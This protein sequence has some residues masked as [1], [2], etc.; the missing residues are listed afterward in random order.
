MRLRARDIA[1]AIGN[2]IQST[3]LV[4]S[5][6]SRAR[7]DGR[8]FLSLVLADSTGQ[9]DAVIRS[10]V[11][12]ADAGFES[13]HII[14]VDGEVTQF[15]QRAQIK[16]DKFRLKPFSEVDPGDYPNGTTGSPDEF[17]NKQGGFGDDSWIPTDAATDVQRLT[18][19][20]ARE[21]SEKLRSRYL[22]IPDSPPPPQVGKPCRPQRTVEDPRARME[23]L[24][25]KYGK[26]DSEDKF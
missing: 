17:A 13:G 1:F 4:V 19:E 21:L 22:R 25:R 8:P 18:Q 10:N 23:E 6:T 2:R 20:R 14:E 16:I 12:V 26:K 5:K 11:S 9:V 3:F 7:K 15:R 24:K